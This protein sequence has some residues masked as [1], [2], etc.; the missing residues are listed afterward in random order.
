MEFGE[1]NGSPFA[2]VY[3]YIYDSVGN[4]IFMVGSGVP[5]GNGI[6]LDFVSP[7]GMEFGV[8]DPDSV[9]RQPGGTGRIEF[10]DDSNGT[11]SYEPSAFSVNEWGHTAVE[12]LPLTKLFGIPTADEAFAPEE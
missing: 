10:S 11:F 7:V 5:D 8:F 6:D 2:V 9:D 4:P 12:D 1:V 3:W